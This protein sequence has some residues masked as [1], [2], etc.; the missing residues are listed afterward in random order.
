P[1][2]VADGPSGL[3][4]HPWSTAAFAPYEL[5]GGRAPRAADEVVTTGRWAAVGDTLRTGH[6]AVRVV[7]TVT[8]PV[9]EAAVF[10]TDARAARLAPESEQLVVDADPADVRRV[11]GDRAQVLTGDARRLAD[12]DPDRDRTAVTALNALFGTAGGVAAFVSVSVVAS[13]FAFTVAQRR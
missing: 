9:P 6:G 5:T 7:G 2:R 13:T 10:Y 8:G 4:G 12:A 3:V 1:V 11:V